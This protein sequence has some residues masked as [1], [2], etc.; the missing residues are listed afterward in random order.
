MAI[1]KSIFYEFQVEVGEST[2]LFF[3][4]RSKEFYGYALMQ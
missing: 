1:Q 2:F 4:P 3:N